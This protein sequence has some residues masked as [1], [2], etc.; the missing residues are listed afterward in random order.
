MTQPLQKALA[1]KNSDWAP[2]LAPEWQKPYMLD[3]KS[4]L[5]QAVAQKRR[6]YPQLN[7]CFNAFKYTDFYKVKVVILGQDP[8][9]GPNQA[10]GLSFSVPQ[11]VPL[12]PSL[13]N[14]FK[15]LLSDAQKSGYKIKSTTTGTPSHP[16]TLQGCLTSWAE[17]GVLLLNSVLSVEAG[18]PASH[19]DWGWQQLTDRAIEQLSQHRKGVVF[20]LWGAYAQKKASLIDEQKHLVLKAPHPSPLS[21]HRGFLGCRHF[22]KTN[23]YLAQQ[24]KKPITWLSSLE[25]AIK[26]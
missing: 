1:L 24:G 7:H 19:R 9:H 14:I 20:L 6:I 21:A 13:Q 26:M 23:R 22:S 11:G 2:I 17:Q 25:A 8:Y 16:Q 15:E 12:P 18:R 3:L 4:K 5:T 10:H